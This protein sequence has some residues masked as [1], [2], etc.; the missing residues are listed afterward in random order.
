MRTTMN[1]P[2]AAIF[3][4]V[5]F[6]LQTTVTGSIDI[7]GAAPNL[8]LCLVSVFA[9]MYDRSFGLVYGLGFGILLDLST[10]VIFGVQT[11]TFVL[12]CV[13]IFIF[14]QAL[15]PL[16]LLPDILMVVIATFIN[17]F[18]VWGFYHLAGSPVALHIMTQKLPGL[19]V[20]HAVIA[21]ALHLALSRT[22]VH[23]RRDRKYIGGIL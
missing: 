18:V 3:F 19:V 13:P 17:A 11:I 10:Q 14:R 7:L 21:L 8:L 9:Y 6:L 16:K 5:A 23:A 12:A 1:Y 20:M 4:T 22:F 15:N 2:K